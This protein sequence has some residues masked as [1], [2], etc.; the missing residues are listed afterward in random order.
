MPLMVVQRREG[1]SG[2]ETGRR[3]GWVAGVGGG[4]IGVRGCQHRG[5]RPTVIE[6]GGDGA[7]GADRAIASA[8]A[9]GREDDSELGCVEGPVPLARTALTLDSRS[10]PEPP[11]D[12]SVSRT[13]AL[14][15]FADSSQSAR[16]LWHTVLLGSPSCVNTWTNASLAGRVGGAR[17]SP[18]LASDRVLAPRRRLPHTV[19]WW[20]DAGAIKCS[21]L[22]SSSAS[23]PRQHQS[24]D[25]HTVQDA[26][27]RPPS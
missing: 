1:G 2:V 24:R 10:V 26:L 6:D 22:Q 20:T 14:P 3:R 12:D 16:Q 8:A 4:R 27:G 23:P 17:C 13:T 5:W 21:A 7:R 18:Q 15:F 25:A 11:A 9:S 19:T